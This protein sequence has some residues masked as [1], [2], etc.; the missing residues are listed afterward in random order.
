MRVLLLV[1]GIASAPPVGPLPKGPTIPVVAKPGKTFVVTLPKRSGGFVWRIARP[2]N[3][4]VA[5]EVAEGDR[6]SVVWVRFRAV[7]PGATKIVFAQTRGE[8]AKAYA[9]RTYRV[10]VR[11]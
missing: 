11:R 7:A 6:G 1:L 10:T 5:N 2:F 9:A 8:R 4:H 3:S